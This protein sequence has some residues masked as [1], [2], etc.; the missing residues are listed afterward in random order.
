MNELKILEIGKLTFSMKV[1]N[2]FIACMHHKDE[3]PPGNER[4]EPVRYL[5]ERPLD[6]DFDPNALWR[7]YYGDKIPGFPVHPHR[8]FET[9]TIVLKGFVDHSD[10]LGAAGRYGNGDVQWMTA[11]AGLQHAE[12]FPLLSETRDN[13]LELFQVW[14][15]LP[16]RDKFSAPYYNMFWN[17]QI[18]VIT[19]ADPDNRPV[20]IRLIAGQYGQTES[21]RPNPHSWAANKDNHVNIWLLTLAPNAGFII[22]KGSATLSR[23]VY[24]YEG[25]TLQVENRELS[26]GFYV[27]LSGQEEISLKN[28]VRESKLLLLEGEPIDEPIVSQ[29]PFVMNTR[30]EIKEAYAD[31]HRTHFGGWPWHRD[32]PVHPKD[33]GR[34]ARYKDGR[35]EEPT[36]LGNS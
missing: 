27:E 7:M 32:D 6:A 25:K 14:L 26:A 12:M 1:K 15:N 20:E 8:G 16:R 9:V 33:K 10:G 31:Y 13:P 28:G 2:P 29:G 36:T 35:I 34:F 4:M 5:N 30:E 21:L 23:M 17:E 24:Y 11:G 22:P 19:A 3:F 18:P